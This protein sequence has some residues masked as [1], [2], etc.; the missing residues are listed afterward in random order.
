MCVCEGEGIRPNVHGFMV[1]SLT[2]TS[3]VLGMFV[4]C[5]VMCTWQIVY[6]SSHVHFYCSCSVMPISSVHTGVFR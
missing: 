6:V 4:C 5:A 2:C 1:N 3:C